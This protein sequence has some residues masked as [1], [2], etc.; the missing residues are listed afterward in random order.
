MRYTVPEPGLCIHDTAPTTAKYAG[1]WRAEEVATSV[2]CLDPLKARHDAE[3][4]RLKAKQAT[5]AVR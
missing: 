4:S 3:M 1:G 5:V 2:V